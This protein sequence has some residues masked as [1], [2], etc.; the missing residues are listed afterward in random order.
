[1]QVYQKLYAATAAEQAKNKHEPLRKQVPTTCKEGGAR[2]GKVGDKQTS[3]K[4][5]CKRQS[6]Q[7][8]PR[9]STHTNQIITSATAKESMR[10]V[11]NTE[12]T[13]KSKR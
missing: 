11:K 2:E 8:Q 4:Q 7:T 6:E 9:K 3:E 5:I 12:N 1:M 10:V 13:N